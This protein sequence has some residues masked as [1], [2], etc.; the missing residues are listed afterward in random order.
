[1]DLTREKINFYFIYRFVFVDNSSNKLNNKL[2]FPIDDF[3]VSKYIAEEFAGGEHVYDLYSCVCH[4]GSMLLLS[5]SFEKLCVIF[6][7]PFNL[8][9]QLADI[10][11]AI[12]RIQSLML[13]IILMTT[14]FQRNARQ[15]KSSSRRMYCFMPRKVR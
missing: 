8:Q 4:F 6:L 9:L 7:C 14:L 1:L 15:M 10:I 13:G 5:S 11:Q 12:Q 2:K 3:D